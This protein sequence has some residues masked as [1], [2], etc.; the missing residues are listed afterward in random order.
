MAVVNADENPKAVK[1]FHVKKTPSILFFKH[2]NIQLCHG[3]E[4]SIDTREIDNKD[5]FVNT[6][7]EYYTGGNDPNFLVEWINAA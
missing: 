3:G 6:I 1:E 5:C 2:H 4:D 7:S